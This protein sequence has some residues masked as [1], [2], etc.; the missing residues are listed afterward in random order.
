MDFSV[1]Y[2]AG[3]EKL[4][5]HQSIRFMYKNITGELYLDRE[6]LYPEEL[7]LVK[8]G[9]TFQPPFPSIACLSLQEDH[10]G[11]GGQRP[12]AFLSHV[13]PVQRGGAA[14]IPPR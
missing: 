3:D 10:S 14:F 13:A 7:T 9:V 6:A 1:I 5:F 4:A 8:Q 12:G 2:R 11:Q